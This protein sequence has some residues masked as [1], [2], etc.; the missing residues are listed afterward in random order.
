[1]IRRLGALVGDASSIDT[2]LKSIRSVLESEGDKQRPHRR[3]YMMLIANYGGH[4]AFATEPPYCVA[5][6][7]EYRDKNPSRMMPRDPE[8]HWYVTVSEK[9]IVRRLL[10]MLNWDPLERKHIMGGRLLIPRGVQFGPRLF[11]E[12][13]VPRN[14]AGPPIDP[15]TGHDAPLQTV[16]SF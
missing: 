2:A 8:N 3:A 6:M 5:Y 11:P 7:A 15:A 12:L 9:M 14:H 10:S 4:M 13:V 1:M 16:G